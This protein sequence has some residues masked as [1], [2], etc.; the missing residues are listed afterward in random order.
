MPAQSGILIH[1]H[2]GQL[3]LKAQSPASY[4]YFLILVESSSQSKEVKLATIIKFF[5]KSIYCSLLVVF[6]H[7]LL[8]LKR[9]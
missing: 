6:T 4:N 5:R 3:S 7:V 1:T 9:N 2:I 8:L